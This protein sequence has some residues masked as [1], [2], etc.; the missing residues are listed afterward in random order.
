MVLLPSLSFRSEF[1]LS[2]DPSLFFFPLIL[3]HFFRREGGPPLHYLSHR[4][5]N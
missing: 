3:S 4:D 2:S 1:F 5:K